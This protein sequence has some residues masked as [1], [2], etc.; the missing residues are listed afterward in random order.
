MEW[1]SRIVGGWTPSAATQ[2]RVGVAAVVAQIGVAL[3]GAVVRVTGSG[4]GCPTWPECAPGSLLPV[5]DPALGQAHQWIEFGNRL[6]GVAVGLVGALALL[7]A[8]LTRPRR[9]R[10]LLLAMTMP[11]GVVAQAVIG[12]F[13]VLMELEWWTVAL[14]FVPSPVLVWCAVLLARAA[15]E[16]DG[17][18]RP[19]IPRPLRAMLVVM[20]VA[21]AG[22]LVTGTLVTGAGP[23]AGDADTPRLDLPVAALTQL[24]SDVLFVFLG[25]VVA[26][27]FALR[28]AGAVRTLWRRYWLLVAAV[29]LQGALGAVQ[30]WLGVPVVLA[31]LHVLGAMLTVAAMAGLWAAREERDPLPVAA[32]SDT[33]T[34]SPSR[35]RRDESGDHAPAPSLPLS[36]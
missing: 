5:S 36:G 21:L 7:V 35:T 8:L 4:L 26:L 20:T 3:G 2:R 19:R 18:A 9:R 16:Q 30:Y 27:G 28:A 22:T 11:L 32:A 31:A 17:P 24:H 15:G 13:T 33:S 14:H 6:L 34:T 29:L 12:G 25:L 1:L 10:F 23:H